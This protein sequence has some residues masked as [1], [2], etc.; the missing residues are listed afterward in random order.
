MIMLKLACVGGSYPCL[1]SWLEW[2]FLK[3]CFS[4]LLPWPSL[5]R[6]SF[7]GDATS[8]TWRRVI[9]SSESTTCSSLLAG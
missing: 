7:V 1:F 9:T 8:E 6:T 5:R 3:F 2:R 4:L